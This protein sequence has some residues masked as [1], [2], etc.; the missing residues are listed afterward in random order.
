MKGRYR[1]LAMGGSGKKV[2]K[3]IYMLSFPA[4]S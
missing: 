3:V 1:L 4:G 2:Q